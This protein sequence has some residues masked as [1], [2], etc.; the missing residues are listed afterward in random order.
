M[1]NI[2]IGKRLETHLHLKVDYSTQAEYLTDRF[3]TAVAK[4]RQA[5]RTVLSF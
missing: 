2:V 4:R 5:D 1:R 3:H